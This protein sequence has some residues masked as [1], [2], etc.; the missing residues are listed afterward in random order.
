MIPKDLHLNFAPNF[1][2]WFSTIAVLV[3]LTEVS[4]YIGEEEKH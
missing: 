1:Y 2:M 4:I 3:V